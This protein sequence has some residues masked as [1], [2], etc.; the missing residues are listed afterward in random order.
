M[1]QSVTQS[2]FLAEA[3]LGRVLLAVR[4]NAVHLMTRIYQSSAHQNS[5]RPLISTHRSVFIDLDVS[6]GYEQ[7]SRQVSAQVRKFEISQ[8]P[9]LWQRMK[10][11]R[12]NIIS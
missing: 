8:H 6:V 5:R 10:R 3:N 11:K 9:A 7:I 4:F 2:V 12:R 1:E